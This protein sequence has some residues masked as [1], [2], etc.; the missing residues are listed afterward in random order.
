MTTLT[1]PTA[2]TLG[3]GCWAIGGPFSAGG[4][5]VGWGE[6]DDATSTRAIH[7]ALDHGIRLFDT[8]QAYGTGHSESVLGAALKSHPDVAVVT[9]VGLAID[10]DAKT[11]TSEMTDPAAILNSLEGSFA[12]LGRDHIDVVLLHLNALPVIEATPI[13]DMLDTLFLSGRIGGYGWSTDF[14]DRAGVF[15]DRP[16]FVA[17]E[18]AMNVFFAAQHMVPA[19]EAADLIGFVRSPLAMGILGGRYDASAEFAS[20]DVRS[21]NQSWNGHFADGRVAPDRLAAL[22]AVR[23]ILTSGGRT[24]AQ[25]ALAWLWARS[26]NALPIPGFRT[27][28]QVTDLAGALA[29]GPLTSAQMSEIETLLARPPEGPPQER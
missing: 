23:E 28:Q 12:R 20:N 11:I 21:S 27:P 2:P 18:H 24:L 8:A 29:V 19:V 6:V 3:L 1:P 25:G 4:N 26:P 14:P 13:F 17:V 16:G 9:K 10:P 15:A 22:D 7:T 5:P